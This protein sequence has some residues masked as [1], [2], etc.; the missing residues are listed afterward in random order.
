[1]EDERIIGFTE[2]FNKINVIVVKNGS[3]EIQ[4]A[5][6]KKSDYC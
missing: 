3:I 6:V 4:E 1:L 5:A 2:L